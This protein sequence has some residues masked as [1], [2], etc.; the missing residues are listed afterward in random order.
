MAA[1]RGETRSRPARRRGRPAAEL[2]DRPCR[3][4]RVV[5]QKGSEGACA[6]VAIAAG[7]QLVECSEV[8][9]LKALGAL[10]GAL[11]LLGAQDGGEVQKGAGEGGDGMRSMKVWSRGSSVALCGRS[12]LRRL[13]R[14]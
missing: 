6:P 13:D 3:G 10:V 7:D 1:G 4:R 8:E 2:R 14:P 11:E 5:G 9:D 12:P